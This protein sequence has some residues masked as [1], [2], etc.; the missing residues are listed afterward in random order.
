MQELIKYFESL[1]ARMS[2]LEEAQKANAEKLQANEDKLLAI[3]ERITAMKLLLHVGH[4]PFLVL[5]RGEPLYY[6][7]VFLP[8]RF[9]PA[10]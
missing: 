9:R 8:H 5:G 7:S 4:E 3:G 2:A 10:S 1:E 6:L